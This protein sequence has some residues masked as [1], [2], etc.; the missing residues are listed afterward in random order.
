MSGIPYKYHLRKSLHLFTRSDT[1]VKSNKVLIQTHYYQKHDRVDLID[2]EIRFL[3]MEH[4]ESQ[5]SEV[6]LCYFKSMI[7]QNRKRFFFQELFRK[8]NEYKSDSN[9]ITFLMPPILKIWISYAFFKLCGNIPCY[10]YK[11][12]N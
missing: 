8:N 1:S 4:G 9:Y 11:K 2:F 3:L 12:I 5:T 7:F 10:A 6:L